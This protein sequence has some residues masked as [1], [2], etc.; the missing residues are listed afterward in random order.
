MCTTSDAFATTFVVRCNHALVDFLLGSELCDRASANY[1][2]LLSCLYGSEPKPAPAL[3]L[4][5][6]SGLPVRQ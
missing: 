6:F 5:T 1:S 2:Q 4:T 3:N